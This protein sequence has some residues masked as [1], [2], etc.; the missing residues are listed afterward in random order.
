MEIRVSFSLSIILVVI[1]ILTA[2]RSH[3][4]ICAIAFLLL[5][6][7]LFSFSL[8]C[9]HHFPH[10]VAAVLV[11][12][13]F[14]ER[15]TRSIGQTRGA[16]KGGLPHPT[17]TKVGPHPSKRGGAEA[18][19]DIVEPDDVE[20]EGEEVASREREWRWRHAVV[21]EQGQWWLPA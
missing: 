17:G 11:I 15:T 20:G 10:C 3:H 6:L 12:V 19:A 18:N 1:P 9:G 4:C 13:L 7:L 5:P 21:D 2:P 14:K 16:Q 8:L